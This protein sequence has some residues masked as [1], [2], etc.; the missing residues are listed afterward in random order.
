MKDENLHSEL[1]HHLLLQLYQRFPNILYFVEESSALTK[2]LMTSHIGISQ[3]DAVT[4]RLLGTL[5]NVR[6]GKTSE[7]CM[8]DANIAC[9]KVAKEHPI[10]MLRQLPMITAILQGRASF[11][12]PEVRHRN[13]IVLYKYI[14]G[15]LE[16]LQPY[17]FQRQYSDFPATLAAIFE[18]F[19]IHGLKQH[20]LFPLLSKFVFMLHNFLSHDSNRAVKLLHQYVP[21]LSA[22]S[23]KY[24]EFVTL[25]S[26]LAGLS[27][28]MDEDRNS[29][30]ISPTEPQGGSLVLAQPRSSSPWTVG[31]LLPFQQKI[32]K[33]SSKEDVLEVLNDLDETSKP[34]V[35]VL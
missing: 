9:R 25:K 21:L 26:L 1:A 17:I 7:N 29:R 10:L 12:F 20:P 2:E 22:F 27:L 31:Q 28:P 15:L 24:P 18:L 4:H 35:D 14:L 23:E 11:T 30:P 13:H 6:N 16:L 3:L 34:K 8:Y 32:S 33:G 5:G 19:K